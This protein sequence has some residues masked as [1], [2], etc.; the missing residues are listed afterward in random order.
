MLSNKA[1]DDGYAENGASSNAK[2]LAY[3]GYV[4]QF[5]DPLGNRLIE[6]LICCIDSNNPLRIV[7]THLLLIGS[8]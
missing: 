4:Q 6:I 8:V 2:A 5:L 7:F 1:G 3:A